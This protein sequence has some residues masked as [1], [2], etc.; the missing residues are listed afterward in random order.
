[1]SNFIDDLDRYILAA[2]TEV[3]QAEERGGTS[4]PSEN[5]E[6]GNQS[7]STGARASEHE[8]DVKA[9]VP[10]QTVNEAKGSEAEGAGRGENSPVLNTVT[11]SKATGE[12]AAVETASAKGKPEDPGTSHPAKADMGEKFSFAQLKGIGDEI[13]ADIAVASVVKS[14]AV[15]KAE[16]APAV[17]KA[18]KKLEAIISGETSGETSGESSG[19]TSGETS[20][21]S[22]EKDEK[23]AEQAGKEAA[24]AVINQMSQ[25]TASREQII[26]SIVKQASADAANVADYL[27][28]FYSKQA[29]DA[30]DTGNTV[31]D[32]TSAGPAGAGAATGAGA[33]PEAGAGAG[34]AEI[35]QIVQALLQAGVSP[36]ELL[37]LVQGGGA[38]GGPATA[39]GA[40]AEAMPAAAP[41]EMPA[42]APKMASAK[43]ASM[44]SALLQVIAAQSKKGA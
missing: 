16:E 11:K 17:E 26:D 38:E 43:S 15:K 39:A 7:A 14:A 31:M 8:K 20:G 24:A 22:Y 30:G 9:Q 40:G 28:G 25:P 44:K 5:A 21:E 2:V 36:E 13:L 27:A 32:E 10:G 6:D 12:D 35:E 41:A 18:E 19:E 42:E 3:K 34:D 37:A 4:H 33:G 23:K 29:M 1:M